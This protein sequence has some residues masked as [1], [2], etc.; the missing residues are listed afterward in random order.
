[1]GLW[2]TTDFKGQGVF[3]LNAGLIDKS[4]DGGAT[5]QWAGVGNPPITGITAAFLATVNDVGYIYASTPD[6]YYRTPVGVWSV[7]T[8][9][10]SDYASAKTA[11]DVVILDGS[12]SGSSTPSSGSAPQVTIETQLSMTGHKIVNGSEGTAPTDFIIL[13]QLTALSQALTTVIN[14][15]DAATQANINALGVVISNLPAGLT[16]AQVQAA[17]NT[18]VAEAVLNEVIDDAQ[19]QALVDAA[20]AQLSTIDTAVIGRVGS[21]EAILVSLEDRVVAL[22]TLTTNHTADL[23]A[24]VAKDASQDSAIAALDSGLAAVVLVNNAQ[25]ARL[26]NA[27]SAAALV[28]QA[29][30]P[31]EV[32]VANGSILSAIGVALANV[33]IDNSNTDHITVSIAL[34]SSNAG[35]R[36]VSSAY[37][38]IAGKEEKFHAAEG[39]NGESYIFTYLKTRDGSSTVNLVLN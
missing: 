15:G 36:R 20:L 5:V 14:A 30:T 9:T 32:Q 2:T 13:S 23:A 21:A 28:N 7:E 22:E 11:S 31:V 8:V 29:I 39:R 24:G 10:A 25:N 26:S 37:R 33:S 3:R 16:M 1:M 4:V 19:K 6:A 34:G 38:V 27:E 12:T 17:I 18:A 35:K